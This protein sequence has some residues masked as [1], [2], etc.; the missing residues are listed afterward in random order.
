[1]L[2]IFLKENIT[3]QPRLYSTASLVCMITSSSISWLDVDKRE[4][5]FNFSPCPGV[6]LVALKLKDAFL[7]QLEED[8]N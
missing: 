1:M 7:D 5:V 8:K 3:K 4:V 2:D 6:D